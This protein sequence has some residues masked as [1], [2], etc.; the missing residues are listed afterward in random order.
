MKTLISCLLII[1]ITLTT[2]AST[3]LWDIVSK[4]ESSCQE[5]WIVRNDSR[6]YFW[7]IFDFDVTVSGNTATL[8]SNP[9][10]DRIL[11][12]AGAWLIACFG[13]IVSSETTLNA[14]SYFEY[15]LL[16]NGEACEAPISVGVGEVNYLKIVLQDGEQCFDYQDGTRKAMPDCYYGW[17]AYSVDGNGVVT[18]LSSA[19]DVS[20]ESIVVGGAVPE[21]SSALLF[22]LGCAGLLL[23]RRQRKFAGTP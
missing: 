7:S 13:D 8:N 2:E 15:G 16:G 17:V 12:F 22:L 23:K 18:V 5:F 1:M 14:S 19:L 10:G 4:E 9:R 21:P 20:G 3:V 6:P 11:S